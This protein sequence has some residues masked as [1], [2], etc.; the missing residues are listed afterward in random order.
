MNWTAKI[1]LKIQKTK[2]RR[3]KPNYH[4]PNDNKADDSKDS[5]L[6]I[7]HPLHP[8]NSNNYLLLQEAL[9]LHQMKYICLIKLYKN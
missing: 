6:T 2:V 4:P 9:F 8:Q 3:L 5:V 1:T 7:F